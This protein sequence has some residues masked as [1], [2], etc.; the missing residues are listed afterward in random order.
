MNKYILIP[1]SNNRYKIKTQSLIF[2]KQHAQKIKGCY[3]SKTQKS[4][5]IP[6]SEEAKKQIE[7]LFNTEV[8][9]NKYKQNL[10]TNDKER[11]ETTEHQDIKRVQNQN[12][13]YVNLPKEYTETLKLKRYSRNT[14][15]SYISH[16]NQF[17][18]FYNNYDPKDITDE[19]IREY[20]LYIINNKDISS[21]YQNQVINSIKFYYEKVLGRPTSKYYFQRPKKEKKLPIVLSEEEV[22]SILKQISNLKHKCIIYLIYSAGLRL[23]EV[24]DLKITDIDSK[25]NIIIIRDAKGKKDRISLL[26][27]KVVV[28]LRR[29]Y[30][31]YRPKEW[32]FE[33]QN[34]DKYSVKSVQTIFKNALLQTDIK[35][36]ATIHTLRHSF[37][38][39]LLERGTDLRYIQEILGHKSSRTTEIYTH[40]TKKGL[41]KIKSPLDDM[42]ID[43]E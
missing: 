34:G 37:A 27:E 5:V 23:S 31:D 13:K 28:L 1:I 19:Q 42:Q 11:I 15:K 12:T 38:T 35:K 36:K 2:T 39:H 21:S 29:Y 7:N 20:L 22:G 41:D 32:L 30:K 24:V 6:Q 25:R 16:F 4:W 43:D 18:N 9:V 8:K 40:I 14:I 26:S 3:W 17:L 33:G 10:N